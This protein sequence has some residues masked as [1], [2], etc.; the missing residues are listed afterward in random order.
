[1]RSWVSRGEVAPPSTTTERHRFGTNF[2][3]FQKLES[4]G[5]ATLS[6]ILLLVQSTRDRLTPKQRCRLLL[7]LL[8]FCVQEQAYTRALFRPLQACSVAPP[9]AARLAVP[10]STRRIC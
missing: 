8:L 2:A 3:R 9:L 7:V 4:D 6:L 1:M 5:T 10:S